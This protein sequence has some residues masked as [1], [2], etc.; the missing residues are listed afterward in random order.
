MIW[1]VDSTVRNL[2]PSLHACAEVQGEEINGNWMSRVVRVSDGNGEAYYVKIY[3]SRGRW[4]KRFLVDFLPL[5]DV[6]A[7]TYDKTHQESK[8]GTW[9]RS[10]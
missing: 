9:N 3:A 5:S 1:W 8:Y 10:A 7:D 4:L 6:G 2:F